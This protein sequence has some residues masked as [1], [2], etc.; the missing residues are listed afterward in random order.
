MKQKCDYMQKEI[1]ERTDVCVKEV[2]SLVC[3]I[4]EN[5]DCWLFF[6]ALFKSMLFPGIEYM[7]CKVK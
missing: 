1:T 7:E 4:C 2:E 3:R 5:S 6:R